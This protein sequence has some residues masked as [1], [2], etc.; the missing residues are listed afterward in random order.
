MSDEKITDETVKDEL[1]TT[2]SP[3]EELAALKRKAD[4]LGVS[5]NGNIGVDTLRARINAKMDG[6]KAPEEEPVAEEEK[7]LTKIQIR[8]KLIKEKTALVRCRIANMNPAKA[9]LH[10]EFITVA[11]KFIG[12]ITKFIPFGDATENGYHIPRVIYEDLKRRKFQQIKTKRKNGNIELDNRMVSEYAIE[13]LPP[14]TQ[15]ELDD[16]AAAQAAASRVSND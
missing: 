9:E 12:T 3:A 8:E 16:L 4:I 11:N 15:E 7:P 1:E 6:E 2:M 13:I 5:Y 10:G 14:L